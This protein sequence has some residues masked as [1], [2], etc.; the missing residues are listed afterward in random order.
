MKYIVTAIKKITAFNKENITE[1]FSQIVKIM[2][3]DGST[4][5]M[6]D[7]VGQTKQLSAK[8]QDELKK[9]KMTPSDHGD[10]QYASVNAEFVINKSVWLLKLKQAK[11]EFAEYQHSLRNLLTILSGVD[12]NADLQKQLEEYRKIYQNCDTKIVDFLD[13]LQININKL[14]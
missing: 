7:L 2:Q 1:L 11:S 4:P 6:K 9:S 8:I 10:Y 12:D 13:Q 5:A 14:E 3:R